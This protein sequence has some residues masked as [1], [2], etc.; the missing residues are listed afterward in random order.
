MGGMQASWQ[1]FS[2]KGQKDQW[3]WEE[4]VLWG[5]PVC[6]GLGI[7]GGC[8]RSPEQGGSP[9]PPARASPTWKPLLSQL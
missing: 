5:Q 3:E 7:L 8:T 9:L 4:R 1:L 2:P 6:S